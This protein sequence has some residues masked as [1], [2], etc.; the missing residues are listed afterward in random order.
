MFG[1]KRYKIAYLVKLKKH[2]TYKNR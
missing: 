1:I 2:I